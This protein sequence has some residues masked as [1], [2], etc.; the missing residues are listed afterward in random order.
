MTQG[1]GSGRGVIVGKLKLRFVCC[2]VVVLAHKRNVII[3]TMCSIS[4]GIKLAVAHIAWQQSG[5][6]TSN[7]GRQSHNSTLL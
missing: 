1:N 4:S 2:V 6:A 7:D 3:D 5:C